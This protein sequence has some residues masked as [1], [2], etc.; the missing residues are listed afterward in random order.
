MEEKNSTE[1]R[2][3]LI[4][5]VIVAVLLVVSTFW[6]SHTE[7]TGTNKAVHAVSR[8]YL[9]ELVDRREQVII[10]RIRR[11]I[12]QIN[13]TV[14]VL[15]AND[16]QTPEAL[17]VFLGR[18][19]TLYGVKQIGFVGANGS[20]FTPE[21][22]A[23]NPGEYFFAGENPTAPEVF[24]QNKTVAVVVPVNNLSFQNVPLKTCFILDEMH[25]LL[26]GL[27]LHTTTTAMTFS[28][29]YNMNGESLT[30]AVLGSFDS[31]TNLLDALKSAEFEEGYSLERIRND[32]A[33]SRQGSSAFTFRGVKESLYY[34]PIEGTNWILTFLLRESTI[35]DEISSVNDEMLQRTTIRTIFMIAAMIV[36]FML[37]ALQARKNAKLIYQKNL[38]ET[39][40]RIKHGEMEEKLRLQTQLLSEER[41]R[42]RQSEMIQAL[43]VDYRLV[44]HLN[45]DSD[46][47]VCYRVAPDVSARLNRHV[48]DVI[49]FNEA[50]QIYVKEYVDP[51]D[52]EDLLN[53]VK[54]ENIRE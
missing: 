51:K 18:M 48:S 17:N 4:G 23:P 19:R 25:N 42:R 38:A 24:T 9:R 6:L 31:G 29:L 26:E 16:L 54:P 21:G 27:L 36:V 1:N 46:E 34:R 10:A 53:F 43:T 32:F 8:V 7:E 39:E 35:Q 28:N 40:N 33:N 44:Y 41:R 30:D 37:I 20:I 11:N 45:L 50:L 47:A 15:T 5:G 12:M 52:S 49:R 2:T 14:K 13:N 22:I 3:A